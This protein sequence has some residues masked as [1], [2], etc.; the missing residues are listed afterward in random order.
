MALT[1]NLD[2][3]ASLRRVPVTL[4]MQ[5][6]THRTVQAKVQPDGRIDFD[7]TAYTRG[8]DAPGLRREYELA[9]RQKDTVRGNLAQVYPSVKIEN[10]HVDGAH[11]IERDV[12]VKFSGSIDTFAGQKT[13]TLAPSWLPH[14]YVNSL[15]SLETRTQELQLP[16][17]WTTE[18]EIHFT[19]PDGAKLQDLPENLRYD[20]PFGTAMIRYERRGR[21]LVIATSVQFRKLRIAPSEYAAFREFCTN[22]EDAFHRDIRVRLGS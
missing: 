7:G 11:D 14:K 17:P 6:Y 19:L 22:V 2:G 8:E 13:L 16:A 21:D 20:T 12:N 10:V 4:P 9:D 3:S 1:V 15:A 18:E 5:N